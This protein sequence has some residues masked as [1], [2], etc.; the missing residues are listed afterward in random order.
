MYQNPTRIRR[1]LTAACLALALLS[2][3]AGHAA[4]LAVPDAGSPAAAAGHALPG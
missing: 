3:G 1:W 4:P 2:A